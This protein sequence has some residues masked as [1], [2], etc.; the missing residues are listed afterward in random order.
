MG[1]SC[2]EILNAFFEWWKENYGEDGNG[3]NGNGNGDEPWEF[4]VCQDVDIL[5]LWNKHEVV[6]ACD[7]SKLGMEDE[8]FFYPVDIEDWM[9]IVYDCLDSCPPYTSNTREEAGFDCDDFADVFPAWAKMF[10]NCNAVW[11]VWGDTPQ[12][13]HAWNAV[14]T[15]EGMYEVEPQNGECW[16]FGTN[17]EY[18]AI[19]AK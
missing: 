4:G 9:E 10:W 16:V 2:I 5:N 17:P 19:I 15:E 3:D 18:K 7:Q 12:G 6:W 8:W 14:M 1:K 11:E 13:G